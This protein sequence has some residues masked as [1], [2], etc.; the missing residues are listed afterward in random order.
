MQTCMCNQTPRSGGHRRTLREARHV[1]RPILGMERRGAFIR[2][3]IGGFGGELQ[4][5]AVAAHL[6][7]RH[8]NEDVGHIPA[9]T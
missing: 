4:Q 9:A 2:E 5:A 6:L 8:L 3:Q 7:S 1:V